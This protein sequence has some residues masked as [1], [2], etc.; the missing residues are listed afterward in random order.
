MSNLGPTRDSVANDSVAS[1]SVASDSVASDNAAVDSA[2]RSEPAEPGAT[3]H[4]KPPHLIRR[5][6]DWVI[7]WADTRYG[8]PALFLI[9][10]AESSFFPIPPDVLQLALSFARPSRSFF[11]AAVNA[12]GSLVGAVIGWLIGFALW[13][14]LADFFFRFVPG[15]TMESVDHVGRLY[16]DNAFLAILGAAFTPI[17]FKVFTISAGVF[18]DYVPLWTLLLASALGRTARF[19]MLAIC[20]RVFGPS[21]RQF[22]EKYFELLTILLFVLLIGGFAAIKWLF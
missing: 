8:T 22:F 11:Y 18:H 16:Q 5:L 12:V 10:V 4:V 3:V 1:D 15:V 2:A 19:S 13:A 20:V 21:M 17:P 7:S 6:Y 9:S 14:A